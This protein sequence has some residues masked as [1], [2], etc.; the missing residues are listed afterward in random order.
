MI[1]DWHVRKK[2]AVYY[3]IVIF[4]YWGTRLHGAYA[5]SLLN[6]AHAWKYNMHTTHQA[7]QGDHSYLYNAV[8]LPQKPIYEA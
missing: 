5:Y 3:W 6:L 2:K 1:Y 8:L 4:M 7:T